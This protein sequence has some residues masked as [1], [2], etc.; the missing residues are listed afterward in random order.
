MIGKK[1]VRRKGHAPEL[2]QIKFKIRVRLCLLFIRKEGRGKRN[3]PCENREKDSL[4]NVA[5]S[6]IVNSLS[7]R[8]SVIF[9]K[10]NQPQRD[11]ER[12]MFS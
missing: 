10:L 8:L 2:N 7:A 12:E 4:G 5:F 3:L 1:K 9:M 11:R 6:S